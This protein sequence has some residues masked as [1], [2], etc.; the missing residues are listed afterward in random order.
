MRPSRERLDRRG[1]LGHPLLQLGR[2]LRVRWAVPHQQGVD[3][4]C[5]SWTTH[6]PRERRHS[7][8]P[9]GRRPRFGPATLIEPGKYATYN[10]GSRRS[11][12][13]YVFLLSADD[14]S[15]LVHCHA[16]SR[17]MEANPFSRLHSWMVDRVLRRP[18]AACTR[19]NAE[20]VGLERL[21]GSPTI[22]AAGTNVIRLQRR[23]HPAHRAREGRTDT[24]EDLPHSG[25]HEW[26]MRA[27]QVADVGMVMRRSPILLSA[28]R[29]EHEP[30]RICEYAQQPLRDQESLRRSVGRFD[31][32]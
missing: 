22:A 4:E 18:A 13:K 26:W 3:V 8:R 30:H 20:L 5:S 6:R 19:A 29:D 2:F 10:L 27:S 16:L 21:T 14:S 17:L 1:S 11:T 28:T 24:R 15:P 25:D 12:G 9:C 7:C 31:G 32:R 23:P